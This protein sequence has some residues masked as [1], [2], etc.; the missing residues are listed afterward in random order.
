MVEAFLNWARARFDAVRTSLWLV[1]LLMFHLGLALAF[2]ALWLDSSGLASD[3]E[4]SSWMNSGSG[5]DARNLLSTLLTA[6][7]SL[8]G[9]VFSITVVALS[10]AASAYGPRLIRTFQASRATQFA[11]GT[12]ALTIV[13]LLLVLRVLRGEGAAGEVPHMAVT[14][15]SLLA[16]GCVLA[17][18]G[19][20]QSVSSLLIADEVVRRVRHVFDRVIQDLPP[21]EDDHRPVAA[22]LPDDFELRAGR[23][24]LPRE[25]YVQAME[26]HQIQAW[27]QAH[28]AIVRLD[29][30]PGDFAVDGDHRVL[31]YP[32]PVDL[33]KARRQI[34]R[35]IVSGPRR[36]PDQDYEFAIR[37]LVEVAV[38]ALS[39][40]INDPFTAMAVVDRLHG[41]LARLARR[42]LPGPLLHDEA[43]ALRVVR[44]VSDFAGIVDAAFDQIRQSAAGKPS[45]LIHMLQA[46]TALA[47]HLG[48]ETQRSALR[49]HAGL[50]RAALGAADVS[51]AADVDREYRRALA[52]LA[53]PTRAAIDG[54]EAAAR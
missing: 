2:G 36:T 18:V 45:V 48:T 52:A 43:G 14:L 44:R 17:L 3:G 53:E 9:I 23:L 4:A 49:R 20:L 40:G 28:D 11:L 42:R 54:D 25:G 35:F 22:D 33:E 6:V 8:A 51:A 29:I 10:L 47:E 24:R 46:I 21:I 50:I 37:H 7:I 16:L 32:A 26:F 31:V 41:A 19:F 27:A 15:G 34:G 5:E 39:P 1:P 30:R 38:R 13:Y 12:F